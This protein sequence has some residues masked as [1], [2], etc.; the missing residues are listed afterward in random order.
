MTEFK[1]VVITGL[2]PV[3]PIGTG[4]DAYAQA[5]REGK[6]G[7]GPI[8]RFDPSEI[9]SRIAGEV[10]LDLSPWIDPREARRLDRVVQL[11]L[12]AAEL[13]LSLIHI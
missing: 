10:H 2:G 6:S 12:V 9:S 1:R 5:Q 4:K 7:I 3:T 8:T 13:A 11:G